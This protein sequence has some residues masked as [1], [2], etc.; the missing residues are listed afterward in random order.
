MS[1][2]KG[3]KVPG[4]NPACFGSSVFAHTLFDGQSS[5][6]RHNQLIEI[7]R[8]RITR[9]Q[10][11]TQANATA[12]GATISHVVTP[13]LIDLQINGA[14]DTQFN[15][16]PDMGA[17]IR[18]AEGARRGGAAHI[19]P[20]FITAPDQD[21]RHALNAAAEAMANGHAEI[22]GVHLEGPF[23]SPERPGI[24][25][26]SA[27]RPMTESDLQILC[28]PFPGRLMLTLAPE[29]L[30][31]GYMKTLTRAAVTVF[32]GH[33]AATAKAMADAEAEGLRGATHLFNAMSQ[34][35]GRQP[36]AV[37]AVLA[38]DGL[39]AG[40]IPDGHHVAPAN[41]KIA[42]RCMPDRLCLVTDAMLTLQGTLQR[43]DLNGY[44]IRLGEGRLTNS[45]GRLAGAHIAMDE[46]LSRM[47]DAT[48]ISFA[49]AVRMATANPAAA[50]G[51][52]DQLGTIAVG[53]R[54]SLT[55][56]NENLRATAVMVDGNMKQNTMLR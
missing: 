34:M 39:Y 41:L 9:L 49:S 42:A 48:G 28:E 11:C 36:G 40:I 18:I 23:L 26:A 33:T 35:S 37:G 21:Y 24:H 27:I 46:C 5:E 38:S 8:G 45:E 32:A 10:P 19:M 31:A 55:L 13:G 29:T 17:L 51:L 56:L 22:L 2:R 52:A 7:A 14:N 20:T 44:D 15:F 47:C 12:L 25:D 4:T 53:K 54:A 1:I 43:F 6:P 16:E 3:Q 50:L 30:P